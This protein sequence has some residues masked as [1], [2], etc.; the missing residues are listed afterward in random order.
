MND[1]DEGSVNINGSGVRWMGRYRS[2]KADSE[3]NWG[4]R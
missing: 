3:Y 1:E 4:I 2:E